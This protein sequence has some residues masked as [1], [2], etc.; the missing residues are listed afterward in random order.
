M[1]ARAHYCTISVVDHSMEAAH[2]GVSSELLLRRPSGIAV[3]GTKPRSQTPCFCKP[4]HSIKH[5]QLLV[6]C[7][8]CGMH[9]VPQS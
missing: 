2:T 9:K 3:S 7:S 1:V 8:T 4:A 6:G 5:Q